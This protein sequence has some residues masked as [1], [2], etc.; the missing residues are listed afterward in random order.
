MLAKICIILSEPKIT[1][2]KDKEL[3][4]AIGDFHSI[5][6]RFLQYVMARRKKNLDEQES[7]TIQDSLHTCSNPSD[8]HRSDERAADA[9]I[10]MHSWREVSTG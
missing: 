3:T 4:R 7:H 2:K 10:A 8:E 5:T 1:Q 6:A 9:Q